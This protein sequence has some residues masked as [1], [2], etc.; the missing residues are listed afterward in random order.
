MTFLPF[1]MAL[2]HSD[3]WKDSFILVDARFPDQQMTKG[4]GIINIKS[5]DFTH[6]P[7]SLVEVDIG[8]G[9]GCT[10]FETLFV[11]TDFRLDTSIDCDFFVLRDP[12]RHEMIKHSAT[13]S[14]DQLVG[15]L[16]PHQENKLSHKAAY[17]DDS[18]RFSCLSHRK[19]WHC[20]RIFSLTWPA[21]EKA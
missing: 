16:S 12:H 17:R 10:T 8:T 18:T 1:F 4:S 14:V 21:L 2:M 6:G 20:L 13:R 7:N 9:E 5:S 15:T 11:S 19:S 3:M